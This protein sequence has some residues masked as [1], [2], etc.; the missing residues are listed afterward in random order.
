MDL[1][2][3]EDFVALARVGSFSK[4]AAQRY[5]TQPAFSRRIRSLEDW[6]GA[7]LFDRATNPVELTQ[8][9]K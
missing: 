9:G 3:L 8:A 6:A 7:V 1:E 5:V 4:A 2:W